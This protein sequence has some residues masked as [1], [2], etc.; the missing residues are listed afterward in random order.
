MFVDPNPADD[1]LLF[2][3]RLGMDCV[4]TWL[5]DEQCTYDYLAE[6]RRRVEAAGLRLTNAGNI[7]LGKSDKVHLALPG[8]DEMI[9]QFCAFIRDLGRPGIHTT[10]FT[11][12]PDQVWSS[13]PGESRYSPARRVDLADLYAR[14]LMQRAA[15]DHPAAS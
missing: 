10:T 6:L 8:R 9:D 3:R 14:P 11:W 12:E 15:A 7:R 4:Y 5:K 13:A 2:A 1:E